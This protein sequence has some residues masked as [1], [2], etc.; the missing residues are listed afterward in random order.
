MKRIS[1]VLLAA[2]GMKTISLEAQKRID[3]AHERTS[4]ARQ[5]AAQFA[6]VIDATN[7]VAGAFDAR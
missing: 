4:I 7:D 6:P 1:A 2:F 3:A 5:A